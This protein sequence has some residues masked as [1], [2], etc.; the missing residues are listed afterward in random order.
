M[1]GGFAGHRCHRFRCTAGVGFTLPPRSRQNLA[2]LTALLLA[3]SGCSGCARRLLVGAITPD[4]PF[5]PAAVPAAPDYERPASWAALPGRRDNAD[6][7][8]LAGLRDRQNDAGAD[9]FFIH[10]TTY[11]DDDGW[12]QPMSQTDA[13]RYV[14]EMVLPRQATIFNGACRIF[15]PRYRQATLY[16]FLDRT[17]SG[18]KAFDIAYSD[19]A[20]AFAHFVTTVGNERPII[21]VGHSQGSALGL[22]LLRE[23][24]A[25]TQLQQ[26]LVAAYLVGWGVHKQQLADLAGIE[27]CRAATQTGCV[28]SWNSEGRQPHDRPMSLTDADTIC[29]NPLSWTT[30]N[31]HMAKELNLGSL[32]FDTGPDAPPPVPVAGLVDAQCL[33][34]GLKVQLPNDRRWHPDLATRVLIGD[35]VYHTLD[36]MFFYM[37]IR[38]NAEARV[39]A[40]LD[41]KGTDTDN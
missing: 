21:I 13:N 17:G 26:R 38:Q 12:N 9:C 22:R 2:L 16:A 30:D 20:R 7:L 27:V 31:N 10:G 39:R 18:T 37:N 19:V 29:V 41:T 6:L 28:I 25:G 34:G 11:V 23:R 40:F 8:A 3:L 5:T 35:E 4:Q 14:D 24:I 33:D 15:A 36:Y 1:L 32:I